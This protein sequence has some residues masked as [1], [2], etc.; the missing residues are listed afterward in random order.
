[1]LNSRE[2]LLQRLALLGDGTHKDLLV[3]LVDSAWQ[4]SRKDDSTSTR[5]RKT[6]VGGQVAGS[7]SSYGSGSSSGSGSASSAPSVDQIQSDWKVSDTTSKAFIKNKPKLGSIASYDFSGGAGDVYFDGTKLISITPKEDSKSLVVAWFIC[8]PG[9]VEPPLMDLSLLSNDDKFAMVNGG[10][11]IAAQLQQTNFGVGTSL[12]Y[13]DS[14]SPEDS[15]KDVW[16]EV[17]VSDNVCLINMDRGLRRELQPH[18]KYSINN[19]DQPEFTQLP[20][21]IYTLVLDGDNY[22]WLPQVVKEF[23]DPDF[24]KDEILSYNH[25]TNEYE[26]KGKSS[27]SESM[28]VNSISHGFTAGVPL[29]LSVDGNGNGSWSLAKATDDLS[30][31]ATHFVVEVID[32]DTFRVANYGFWPITG[33]PKYGQIFLSGNAGTVEDS[34]LSLPSGVAIQ[35]LGIADNTGIHINI[36]SYVRD[37]TP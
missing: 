27:Y 26:W 2:S 12:W 35:T 11:C 16:R 18:F 6:I 14:F 28:L 13:L 34:I 20:S 10:Y 29:H 33:L 22:W 7:P 17:N 37:L 24:D 25:L 5:T 1:M 31:I 32:N 23:K 30:L 3:D 21:G 4:W 19:L 15:T 9:Y 8:L 36:T